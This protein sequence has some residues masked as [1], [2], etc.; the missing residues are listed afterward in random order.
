M[1]PLALRQDERKNTWIFK[2]VSCVRRLYTL[3]RSV[4]LNCFDLTS[5]I[6]SC[7]TMGHITFS[8]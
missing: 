3:V 6:Q 7:D 2:K 8:A 5:V 1:L 4:L